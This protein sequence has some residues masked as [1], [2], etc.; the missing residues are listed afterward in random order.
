MIDI[1]DRAD[2]PKE[3]RLD[4]EWLSILRSTNHLLSLNSAY[5]YLPSAGGQ[6]KLVMRGKCVSLYDANTNVFSCVTD[7]FDFSATDEEMRDVTD[8][9]GG[10]LSIPF[11]MSDVEKY[12]EETD[13]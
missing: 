7:R 5:T 3:L 4:P 1:P 2:S 12:D 9:L 8:L 10:N 13:P 11:L 6:E